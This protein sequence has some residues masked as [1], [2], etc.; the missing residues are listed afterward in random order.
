MAVKKTPAK[1]P[2]PPAP[3]GPPRI[4]TLDSLA[5]RM[6]LAVIDLI[7]LRKERF[8]D[9]RAENDVDSVYLLFE[10]LRT[11]ARQRHLY[12]QGREY[13]GKIVT[14][15]YDAAWSWHGYGGAVDIVHPK[16]M[17]AAPERWWEQLALDAEHV[18]LY[19]GRRFKSIPDSP[20]I[21]WRGAGKFLAPLT[22][23]AVDRDNFRRGNVKAVWERYK[24]GA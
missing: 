12:G 13:A 20:H 5:P 11:N 9:G 10:T 17:W 1:K 6:R 19:P 2:L 14:K 23:D 7:A 21:Q 8:H 18:G 15:A 3:V 22:P 4:A 16:L 24:M